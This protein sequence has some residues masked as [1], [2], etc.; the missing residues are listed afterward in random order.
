MATKSRKATTTDV[1]EH[2]LT[3]VGERDVAEILKDY[4]DE[5]VMIS[6]MGTFR[7]LEEIERAVTG[8]MEEFSQADTEI[9]QDELIVE[10]DVGYFVW[11]AETPDNV[12][13]FGTDTY[14][15]RD[16]VIESQTF[17]AK[18]TPKN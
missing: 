3:A 7:G 10:G 15:V 1:V 9:V 2:H 11:H 17:A 5:S 14:I 18:V 8:I 13:E 16:G 12:Y 6:H 4:T